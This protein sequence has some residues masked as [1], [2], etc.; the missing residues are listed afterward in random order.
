M[1]WIEKA[2]ESLLTGGKGELFTRLEILGEK[3]PISE[4]N[5]KG[6][7]YCVK[8][9]ADGNHRTE[10]LIQFITHKIVDYSIP[11]KEIDIAK[12]HDKQTGST[13]KVIELHSKAKSLFTELEKTGEFGELLLYTLVQEVL[14]LPQLISKMSLKT[15]G[16]LHY[17]GA[18]GIHVKY[19]SSTDSL[20]L[21]WGESNTKI[22]L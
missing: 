17:Q 3:L 11:K 8:L 13:S 15:S 4:T 14:G 9:D 12:E 7:C 2:I 18:D 1:T 20:S 21:Y 22:V 10:D 6:Y 16:K 19:E 5:A